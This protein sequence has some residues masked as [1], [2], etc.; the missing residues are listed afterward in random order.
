MAD[1]YV[2]LRASPDWR[3]FDIEQTRPFCRNAGLPEDLIIR[4][5]EHWERTFALDYREFRHQ[6]KQITLRS[7]SACRTSRFLGSIEL[8]DVLSDD[9]LFLFMDDDDWV[10]PTLFDVLRGCETPADGFLWSS[11]GLGKNFA[12]R[13]IEKRAPLLQKRLL[14]DV[15]YT[16]NYCVTGQAIRRLGIQALFEHSR[17]QESLNDKQFSP[18]KIAHYLSCANKHPCSTVFIQFNSETPEILEH[19]RET[20]AGIA[21]EQKDAKLDADTHWVA[22][23]L[24]Q[25]ETVVRRSLLTTTSG[26][27]R[28]IG[29]LS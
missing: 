9:D 5:V 15:I 17:A 8:G 25:F 4:F 22:P 20:I 16:N 27:G 7:I 29:Q 10:A 23:Y 6:M 2:V 21:D 26:D 12:V 24:R 19:L 3:N 14:N 13:P 11:I 18:Q 1:N 28:R